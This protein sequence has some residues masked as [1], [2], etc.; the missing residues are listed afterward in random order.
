MKECHVGAWLEPYP[1]ITRS[2]R[3][4]NWLSHDMAQALAAI[5]PGLRSSDVMRAADNLAQSD[6]AT[7]PMWDLLERG[8]TPREVRTVIEAL[9]ALRDIR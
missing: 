9:R 8:A 4:S 2:R 1:R 3:S 6:N 7:R 5:V